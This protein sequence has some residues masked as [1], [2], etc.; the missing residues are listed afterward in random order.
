MKNGMASSEN[1]LMPEFSRWKTTSGGSPM[2]S[3][4]AKLATPRQN[5]IGVPISI[6][7]VKTPKRIHSSI[8]LY[9]RVFQFDRD[10]G[11]RRF[12]QRV[13]DGIPGKTQRDPLQR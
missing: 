7:S 3:T 6:S 9:L 4:V 1:T 5:A 13:V 8:A 10:F 12:V 11:G 2:Y